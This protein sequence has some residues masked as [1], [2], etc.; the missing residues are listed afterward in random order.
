MPTAF[1]SAFRE[2]LALTLPPFESLGCLG[3][4]F[5]TKDPIHCSQ[6]FER[7]KNKEDKSLT[8]Y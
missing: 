5:N 3:L 6:P 1:K 4:V 8:T 2:A 7:N